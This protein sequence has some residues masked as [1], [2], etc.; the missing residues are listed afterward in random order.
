MPLGQLFVFGFDGLT[1]SQ[2][3][4]QLINKE[5]AAGIILFSRNITSLEQ[6][7][8][9][10]QAI[11]QCKTNEFTPLISVDQE[12]GR[13]ARLK[14]ICTHVPTMQTIGELSTNDPKLPYKLGAMM[15]REL[16]SLGFHL[17]FAPV[18]DVNSN[19][20]NP[21]I[22]DRSFSHD[23]KIVA[24]LSASFIDGM[25]HAG[26]AACAKHFPGHGDTDADSH[27]ELPILNHNQKRI[28][29]L[30]L[31]PFNA[32]IKAKVAS[33]MTA[34]IL[35]TE[36]DANFPATLSPSI[37][38]NLLR[39]K[40]HYDGVVFSDD[41][42]MKAVADRYEIKEMIRLGLLAGIDIFLICSDLTKIHE[43]IKAV[44]ELVDSGQI[45]KATVLA[46]LGR[47]EKLKR[48]YMGAP[49]PANLTEAQQIVRCKPHLS[50]ARKWED[51]I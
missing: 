41:L 36:M 32:A 42:E 9:L 34:H 18:V 43:G 45:P 26:L 48:K 12:G 30:E 20:S 44:H 2:P 46:A 49:A 17:D 7:V 19:P 38:Q 3:V 33:I 13:V 5:L 29:E 6:V 50:L 28:E 10:N 23:A 24:K 40:M 4:K 35:F 39:E 31:I 21:I 11:F 51:E 27:L 25:Q 16:T 1:L 14:N 47:V 8:E 37:L 22:G 15:G